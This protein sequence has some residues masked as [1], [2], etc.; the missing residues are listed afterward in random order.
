ML[1]FDLE[2]KKPLFRR[3]SS[4]F[5]LAVS[6]DIPLDPSELGVEIPLFGGEVSLREARDVRLGVDQ[7]VLERAGEGERER[8]MAKLRRRKRKGSL[9]EILNNR[10]L[11]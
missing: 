6:H 8:D 10:I 11:K 7:P 5:A 9:V 3:T 1:F 4:L 2:K